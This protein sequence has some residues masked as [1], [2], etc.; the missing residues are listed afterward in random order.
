MSDWLSSPWQIALSA[1][2]PVAMALLLF[3]IESRGPLAPGIQASKGVVAPYFSSVAI[4]FGLFAALLANDAWQKDGTARYTVQAEADAVHLIAQL[5]RAAGIETIALPK[6]KAYVEAASGEDP[7]AASIGASRGKT[8]K[9]YQELLAG[10]MQAPGVDATVR[11]ALLGSARDLLRAH[12]DRLYLANDATAA[13]KWLSILVF[14]GITQIA[15]MLVHVGNRRALRVAV[16][17]FTVAFSFCL[18]V[19]AIFDSPFETI[20]SNEPGVTLNLVLK[21]L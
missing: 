10:L 3:T 9:A 4:V 18:V 19:V 5:A 2:M 1:T 7:Y 14:G 8:G 21:S 12:D 6:L 11:A 17:L 13:I 16:S 15:L 20:L